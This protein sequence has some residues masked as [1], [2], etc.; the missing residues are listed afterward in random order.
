MKGLP[1]WSNARTR[2]ITAC[3]VVQCS[4]MDDS[5]FLWEHAIFGPRHTVTPSP[6][7]MKFCTTDYIGEVTRS[8]PHIHKI[9]SYRG[10]YLFFI[11]PERE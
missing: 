1:G 9:Y 10:V 6:I 4:V 8:S 11:L 5:A 3:M 7:D 2:L